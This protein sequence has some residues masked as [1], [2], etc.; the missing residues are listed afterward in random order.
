MLLGKG[1]SYQEGLDYIREHPD[2]LAIGINQAAAGQ[3][4][5]IAT[6]IIINGPP[7]NPHP[8]RWIRP[9]RFAEPDD[10]AFEE[11][12]INDGWMDWSRED[13]AQRNA[14]LVL[15]GT[16]VTAV[17]F[18]WFLNVAQIRAFGFD[19]GPGYAPGFGLPCG[20]HPAETFSKI[21]TAMM[22]TAYLLN[23]PIGFPHPITNTPKIV[24][25]NFQ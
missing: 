12:S 13:I 10:I 19:G 16:G 23:L 2:V 5:G 17:H 4:Y 25:G 9:V 15:E 11:A 24:T 22:S 18:L 3:P 6:D 14:L 20:R 7:T 8:A 1:P 21:R